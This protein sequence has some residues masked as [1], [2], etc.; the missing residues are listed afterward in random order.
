MSK[1][2]A[3]LAAIAVA[4]M[5]GPAAFVQLAH[6][7]WAFAQPAVK[8][9]GAQPAVKSA[10][11]QSAVKSAGAQSAFAQLDFAQPAYAQP[12]TS[13]K[14]A[15]KKIPVTIAQFGHVFLYM[16]LY[17]ALRGGFF[18]EQGLDVKLVST[19][20]DEK[21]FTAVSTGNA[22][23]G[24]SDPTFA[25]IARE[26]GQ[27]G[28]VVAG[29]VKGTP[30]WVITFK[31]EIKPI[32]NPTGF[33]GYKV[34]TYTAPS[35]SYAVMKNILQNGGKPVK[36]ATIVQGAFGTLLPL[37][38]AN[39]ADM[40]LEI[41]PMVSIAIHDGAHIVYAPASMPGDFA[42]TGLTVSDDFFAKHPEQ[43]QAAVNALANAM[44]F[45]RKDPKGT[46]EIAK[47]EFPEVQEAVIQD[48]LDRLV[49]SGTT[50]VSPM[51][52]KNA[53]D[54]AIALRKDLGD[55]KSGGS[56]EQNVDMKF[57]LKAPH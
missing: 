34:A 43:I 11:A 5:C 49:A 3:L 52:T 45:I 32:A 29:I 56:F 30:F 22:Q 44:K 40:A 25:A 12:A 17:V 48:A 38:K 10:G 51:M 6:A 55:I 28:K 18:Q 31:K 54:N 33:S 14:P 53:W 20:G 37:I 15:I 13:S 50:P 7:Q 19:G 16:P 57:V 8:S 42:F 39:H 9:A 4:V 24:V 1:N 23:F 21:T 41:E 35:T 26:H 47:K 46:L 2:L 27:G 36:N